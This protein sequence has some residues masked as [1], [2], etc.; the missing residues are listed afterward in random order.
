VSDELAVTSL[1]LLA[2]GVAALA[3]Y[4]AAL[5]AGCLVGVYVGREGSKPPR[6]AP[7]TNLLPA[8]TAPAAAGGLAGVLWALPQ[9]PD[10]RAILALASGMAA[11]VVLWSLVYRL[12]YKTSTGRAVVGAFCVPLLT[13]PVTMMGAWVLGT[14]VALLL[15]VT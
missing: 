10:G 4:P 7:W 14:L 6:W 12:A 2:L 5:L 8:F 9:R 1:T 11:S 15:A 13:V 3:S